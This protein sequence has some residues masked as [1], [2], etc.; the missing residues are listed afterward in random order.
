MANIAKLE[1]NQAY[2]NPLN[3][4]TNVKNTNPHQYNY[5]TQSFGCPND[6]NT[7]FQ[8]QMVYDANNATS[9]VHLQFVNGSYP[10]EDY[11]YT[12][13]MIVTYNY[14]S[15]NHLKETIALQKEIEGIF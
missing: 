12:F 14:N 6:A 10:K 11:K 5:T 2:N 7:Q 13:K 3:G 1:L 9:S 8:V 4:F 15:S